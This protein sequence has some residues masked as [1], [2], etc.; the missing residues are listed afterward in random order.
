MLKIAVPTGTTTA[1][2]YEA[3]NRILSVSFERIPQEHVDVVLSANRRFMAVVRPRYTW[4]VLIGSILSGVALGFLMEVYRRHVLP[5]VLGQQNIPTLSMVLFQ[6]LPFVMLIGALILMRARTVERMRRKAFAAQLENG[7]FIDTDVYENGIETTSGD[8]TVWMPWSTVREVVV[9]KKRI[10]ILGDSFVAYLP[11]RAF[12]NKA[13]FHKAGVRLAEL[14]R[15]NRIAS[16]TEDMNAEM[17][18]AA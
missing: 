12:P 15:Q 6:L 4:L 17:A 13:I 11:E 2:R 7:Q 1:A 16:L 3:V 14:K 18:A 10:E 8:V 5:L 9:A